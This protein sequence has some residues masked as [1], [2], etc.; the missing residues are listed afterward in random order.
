MSFP[1]AVEAP[2]LNIEPPTLDEIVCRVAQQAPEL[3]GDLLAVL[4]S[5]PELLRPYRER[6]PSTT[7]LA[8]L[9]AASDAQELI[10][11]YLED[12]VRRRYRLAAERAGL[13]PGGMADGFDD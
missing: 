8:R 9:K 10:R 11:T 3:V 4:A 12:R 1:R 7:R 6:Q 2:Q 13:I 5:R